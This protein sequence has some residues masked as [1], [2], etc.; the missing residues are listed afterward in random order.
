LT[1]TPVVLVPALPAVTAV[2]DPSEELTVAD[3]EIAVDAVVVDC[4]AVAV[5]LGG[6]AELLEAISWDAVVAGAAPCRRA[7]RSSS[8][9][10]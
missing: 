7:S 6:E 10:R 2:V 9:N 1:V 4:N 3:D 8:S 5:E